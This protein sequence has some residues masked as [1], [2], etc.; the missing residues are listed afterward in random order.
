M[1]GERARKCGKVKE[2]PL[3]VFSYVLE[4]VKLGFITKINSNFLYYNIICNSN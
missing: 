3:K 1:Q 2:Y 4:K